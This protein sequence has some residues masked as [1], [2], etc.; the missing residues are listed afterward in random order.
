ME[1]YFKDLISEDATLDKLVDDLTRLVQ[2]VDDFARA[3]GVN[4]PE[5][6]REELVSRLGRL[7]EHC[8]R[9]K[10]QAVA[11]AQATDKLLREH[12]YWSLAIVFG[13]GLAVGAGLCRRRRD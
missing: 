4:L 1:V 8:R 5:Q 7:K 9:V 6:S 3:V 10:D 2:G 12:P 13:L 11:G